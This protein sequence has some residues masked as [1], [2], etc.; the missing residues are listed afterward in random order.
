MGQGTRLRAWPGAESCREHYEGQEH[1]RALPVGIDSE[2]RSQQR[3]CAGYCAHFPLFGK[4]SSAY[5]GHDGKFFFPFCFLSSSLVPYPQRFP[6]HKRTPITSISLGAVGPAGAG[7]NLTLHL[8]LTLT[9]RV[10]KTT[11]RNFPPR[12][13]HGGWRHQGEAHWRPARRRQDGLAPCAES[14]GR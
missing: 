6:Q 4:G 13:H 8:H 14:E 2:G 5:H 9:R 10:T 11:G 1:P 3:H 12:A 7:P